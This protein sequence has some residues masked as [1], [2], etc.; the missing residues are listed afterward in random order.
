MGIF[1]NQYVNQANK[2]S[3]EN[4]LLAQYRL[5]R[6]QLVLALVLTAVNVG[7]LLLNVNFY[8][9]FSLAVPYYSVV[10]GMVFA[11]E[12]AMNGFLIIGIVAAVI[13]FA[14]YVL[15]YVLS[16]K[17][18]GCLTALLVLFAIDT[19]A[20]LGVII[21][22][23][24]GS[25]GGLS[26]IFD[27][28]FHGLVLFYLIRGVIAA[29]K[30]KAL[31]VSV[32]TQMVPNVVNTAPNGETAAQAQPDET[33]PEENVNKTVC[34][35]CGSELNSGAAFCHSCGAKVEPEEQAEEQDEEPQNEPGQTK[36]P[37]FK[38]EPA[39]DWDGQGTVRIAAI[40]NGVEV[41]AA[42]KF[43]C[44]E[45]IIDGKV[46]DTFDKIIETQYTLAAEVN[47]V[48]YIYAQ[49]GFG[50]AVLTADGNMLASAVITA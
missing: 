37:E 19:V 21:I 35:Y 40:Y 11:Q 25:E 46:Y 30:L 18:A 14:V 6:S 24:S 26:G 50:Q 15:L 44:T 47:G 49:D 10:F 31:G 42:R 5:A 36:E 28:V 7:T 32:D 12:F 22:A 1:S 45:L 43:S 16:K 2:Q 34:P 3:P 41:K 29:K 4:L 20:V 38:T 9:L 27:I 48:K 13:V 39:G 33:A 17:K 8:F 23:A